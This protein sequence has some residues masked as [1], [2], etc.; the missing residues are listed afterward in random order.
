MDCPFC[1]SEFRF[2]SIKEYKHWSLQIFVDDQHYIGRSVAVLKR[3]IVDI[4]Q[5]SVNER[6]ELFES[7]LPNI[8]TALEEEFNPDLINYSRIGND[9]EHMHLHIIPRYKKPRYFN[10]IEFVDG[11][12]DGTYSYGYSPVKLSNDAVMELKNILSEH[13]GD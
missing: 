12:W 10:G 1:K 7:V 4:T 6:K 8:K 3:H 2:A 11:N 5:L 13:I 9:C